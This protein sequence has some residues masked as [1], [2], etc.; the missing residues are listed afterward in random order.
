MIRSWV[1]VIPRANQLIELKNG[2]WGRGHPQSITEDEEGG[3]PLNG[4]KKYGPRSRGCGLKLIISQM[5]ASFGMVR[6]S[7]KAVLGDVQAQMIDKTR[8]KQS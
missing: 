1:H 6:G 7:Q 2:R 8:I 4:I 3:F 5:N